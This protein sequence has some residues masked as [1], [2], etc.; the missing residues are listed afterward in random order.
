MAVSYSQDGAV[1][2][3]TLDNPPANSYDLAFM[4][5]FGAAVDEAI[6]AG[7]GAVIVR[8]ASEK[9]FSGGA[10]IKKF[11]EGDTAQNMEMIRT[12]HATFDRMAAAPAVF[13]AHIA[14][15][16]MGGG[17][18]IALG[19]DLRYAS[20]GSFRLAT[21][22]V[23]LGLLPGNGG[24]QRIA[25][26]LGPGRG[27]EFLLTGRAITVDEAVELGLVSAAFPAE[28]ADERVRAIAEKFA[29]GPRLAHAHIKRTVYEGLQ[30]PL[31]EGLALE[32]DLVEELFDTHDAREG[33][34][35]FTEK[36]TPAF[37]GS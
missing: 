10:D 33:L 26:L 25:R 21:P 14:G 31:S 34:T 11:L 13:I 12:S 27:L 29:N 23:T 9:F 30:L 18:E 6:G 4:K 8:S 2:F 37:R 28:E 22:E 32:R 1:G 24:T 35:A 7:V 16:A 36:R 17:L 19:C 3:V 20:Q 5:E 15:H